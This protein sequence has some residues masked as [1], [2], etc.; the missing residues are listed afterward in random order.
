MLS[1]SQARTGKPND[2][3]R[4]EGRYG[5]EDVRKALSELNHAYINSYALAI[6]APVLLAA[7]VW[8]KSL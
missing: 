4:Y 8:T 2:Y 7:N 1:K 5:I 3:D 6:E